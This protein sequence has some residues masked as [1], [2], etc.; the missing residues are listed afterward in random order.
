MKRIFSALVLTG[1]IITALP[2]VSFADSLPGFTLFS[3]VEG[4][5]Q[6]NHKL[7]YGGNADQWDRYYLR[8][9]G[10]K[11]PSSITQVIIAYPDY[12][13]GKFDPKKVEIVDPKTK[14][15]IPLANVNWD[16]A[17]QEIVIELK[18]P[19]PFSKS[20][21]VVLNNVKNPVFGGM[22]YFDCKV[23]TLTG[24]PLPRYVGTW[25]LSIR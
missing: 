23:K 5:N 24:D 13:N 8:I 9:P 3:G 22:F 19:L 16:K 15:N 4:K 12:F 6:L 10:N 25:I 2:I 17:K 20:I 18:E 7:E 14:K 11:L 21:E 1:S